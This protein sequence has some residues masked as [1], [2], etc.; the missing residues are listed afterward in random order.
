MKKKKKRPHKQARLYLLN[1]C[2]NIRLQAEGY[3][4]YENDPSMKPDP[5]VSDPCLK[6]SSLDDVVISGFDIDT[7]GKLRL[8][9]DWDKTVA[10]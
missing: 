8:E 1:A 5:S 2:S 4:I 6:H 7:T 10:K 9:I 3:C